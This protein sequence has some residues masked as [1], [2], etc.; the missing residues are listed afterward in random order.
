MISVAAETIFT[1]AGFP[2][3]NSMINAWVGIVIFLIVGLIVRKKASL[4]PRGFLNFV[5]YIIEALLAQAEGVVGDRERARKFFPICATLF[6]FI[7]ISNWIG[8]LPGVGSIGIWEMEGTERILVPLFRP[9]TSDLNF[10]VAI[11]VFAMGMAHVFGLL[12][13]GFVAYISRFINIRG[14]FQSFKHGP[15]AVIVALVEFCVGLLEIISEFAKVLSLS[16]RLFGNIFAGEV[17]LA[18]IY[19]LTTAIVPLPF[20]FLELLIGA[21]QATVFAM[22]TLVFMKSMSDSHEAHAE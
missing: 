22:L 4:T 5:D 13:I 12:S 18:V 7:L 9:P 16:L 6:L 20:I 17:L 14:I 15:M 11:A 2:I 10:T 1:I 21:I 19:M 8:L 3:T